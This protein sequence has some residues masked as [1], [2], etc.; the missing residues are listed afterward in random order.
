VLQE[1]KT[2]FL[3]LRIV[4]ILEICVPSAVMR[5]VTAA[6]VVVSDHIGEQRTV[7]K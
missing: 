6:T 4:T 5:I 1:V 7:I 3:V 2:S